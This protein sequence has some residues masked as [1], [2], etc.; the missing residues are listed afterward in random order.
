MNLFITLRERLAEIFKKEKI[1]SGVFL[2]LIAEFEVKLEKELRFELLELY[3]APFSFGSGHIAYRIK[4][5]NIQIGYDG[6]ENNVQ[7]RY[8][9]PHT[10]FRSG[11]WEVSKTYKVEE[12]WQDGI[13]DILES[14][15]KK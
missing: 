1:E 3:Y 9:K 5:R 15:K 7:L 6:K 10:K 12:F 13:K 14:T 2:N 4:G 11:E 8:S